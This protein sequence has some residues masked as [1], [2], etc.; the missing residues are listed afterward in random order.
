MEL[1]TP[2]M[3]SGNPRMQKE[4]GC[5]PY[6]LGKGKNMKHTRRLAAFFLGVLMVLAITIQ[7]PAAPTETTIRVPASDTHS[8]EIYQIFT[9]DLSE[10]ILSNVKWGQNGT[11]TQ[12]E[13]V[14]QTTLDAI[15]G[16]EGTDAQKAAAIAEYATL[17]SPAYTVSS[18]GSVNVPTGY[19]L[20]RDPGTLTDGDE[21]TLYI[22][23]VTGPTE[24]I[25]KAGTTEAHKTVDDVNDSSPSVTADNGQAQTSSDYDIG[26]A[27]PY[28]ISATLSEAVGQYGKYHITFADTLQAGCFDAISLSAENLKING[29]AVADTENYTVT[30]SG[31]DAASAAGFE[32]TL[33]FT[34]KENKTLESL[35]N[36]V[37]TLD[38]TATLG[39]GAKIGAEGNTNR[40]RLKYSNNPN[41]TTGAQEGETP[42]SCVIT[43][44]YKVVINKVDQN[45]QPLTGAQ[46]ALYKVADTYALPTT[47]DSASRGADAAQ[48][49]IQEYT[50]AVSGSQQ[51]T[52]TFRGVD[53]GRYVLVETTTPDG[54]NTLDPQVFVIQATHGGAENQGIT[55][56]ALSGEKVT[57]EIVLTRDTADE[58]ALKATIRNQKGAIL[59]STGGTGTTMFYIAGAVL[60]LLACVLL[61]T[62]RRVRNET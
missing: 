18:G 12:G 3:Q 24:I 23:Q 45:D 48:H 10:N 57:G 17:S 19:Y 44:T 50:A 41:D 52:F 59:P 13:T 40:F 29:N 47:G 4:N 49:K 28:H 20:I 60:V 5:K 38:F 7:A 55:L 56:D 11:G 35:N 8:Y 26:D 61:V 9:G 62:R 37:V 21:A 33:E 51:D 6:G 2:S 58:D 54:Y 16:L 42:E 30:V 31:V 1:N 43:F 22:V 36:A 39:E 53:D 27:V 15:A 46:F 34:P 32:V 14:P 25:R